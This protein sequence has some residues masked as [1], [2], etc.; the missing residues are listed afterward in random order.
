MGKRDLLYLLRTHL[1]TP[2]KSQPT[3]SY[4]QVNTLYWEPGILSGYRPS[5]H[6]LLY[7]L[8]SV[9]QIHNETVNIWTHLL[10]FLLVL[11][12][13]LSLSADPSFD[14]AFHPVL[15]AFSLCCLAYTF[16]STMAH[17]FH[18]KSPETHYLCFQVDYAGIGFYTL[19]CSIY[20]FHASCHHPYTDVLGAYYLPSVVLMSAAGCLCCCIAKLKYSRPYPFR[21]KLW[22]LFSF[23]TQTILVF[24]LVIPRY[25]NCFRHPTCQLTSLNHHSYVVGFITASVFFFSSHL[26][27]KL[28]PGK[29]DI[30]GQGHQIFHVLCTIGTLLQFDVITWDVRH[31][32]TPNMAPDSVAISVAMLSYFVLILCILFILR[33]FVVKRVKKDLS[34]QT[35]IDSKGK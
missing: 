15:W 27:D 33:P 7:Y 24:S 20:V 4:H 21:R 1:Q 22:Q 29:V 35:H 28:V 16:C 17:T 19:G 23:G 14:P 25:V 34:M 30:I 26:P 3:L 12:R 10:G 13:W 31:Y 6:G 8:A 2:L 11:Y 5:G 18:S 9:F 32:A